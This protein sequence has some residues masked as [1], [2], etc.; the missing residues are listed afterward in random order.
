MASKDLLFELIKSLS[1]SEKRYFKR[2]S[3]L[4]G[5][6]ENEYLDLFQKIDKQK[7]YNEPL[8]L[9]KLKN[10][11]FAKN[12]SSG[13]HYLYQ[14]I[15]KSLRAYHAEKKALFQVNDLVQDIY[16]LME[17]NLVLQA[18]KRIKKAK[19]IADK[20]QLNIPKLGILLLERNL[21]RSFQQKKSAELIKENQQFS[22]QCINQIN[23]QVDMVSLYDDVYL[24][25]RNKMQLK[26]PDGTIQQLLE[27]FS[28][29]AAIQ[30]LSFDSIT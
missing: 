23:A 9:D 18:N 6:S 1:A 14:L 4:Q 12:I 7:K 2:F 15:L 21:I 3:K 22:Q 29:K 16:I 26:D 5:D 8:L 30:I 25:I 28:S 20:Y 24:T 13:K 10:Q 27:S 19:K 11:T 17:K